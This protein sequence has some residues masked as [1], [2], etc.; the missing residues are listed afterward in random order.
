MVLPSSPDLPPSAAN[1]ALLP[2]TCPPTS[3]TS[4]SSTAQ[5]NPAVTSATSL[6]PSYMSIHSSLAPS[7]PPALAVSPPVGSPSGFLMRGVID[8]QQ[9]QHDVT[10]GTTGLFGDVGQEAQIQSSGL[11][12]SAGSVPSPSQPQGSSQSSSSTSCLGL[13][14]STA[15]QSELLDWGMMLPSPDLSNM[16]WSQDPGFG[17]LD[18]GEAS[19]GMDPSLLG[20]GQPA[21]QLHQKGLMGLEQLM[22]SSSGPQDAT[23]SLSSSFSS[24]LH[25]PS[26]PGSQVDLSGPSKGVE[27]GGDCGDQMDMSDWLDVIMPGPSSMAPHSSHPAPQ[28][29]SVDP[30]LTPRTQPDVFDIFNFDDSDFGSS[31]MTW[32]R[33][34]EQST[35]T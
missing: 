26:G 27:D 18:L 25:T 7:P 8:H 1:E 10:F 6:S 17:S 35:S 29:S 2:L 21:S 13:Q 16:D 20:I 32:D 30:I 22:E 15:Q 24:G 12:T 23:A 11:S 34:A 3:K 4:G 31:A 33:L 14:D 28:T 5:A 19:L 9:Q